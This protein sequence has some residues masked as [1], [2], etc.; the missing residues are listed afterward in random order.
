MPDKTMAQKTKEQIRTSFKNAK[1]ITD[2]NEIAK[3]IKGTL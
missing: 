3:N 2:P 1:G